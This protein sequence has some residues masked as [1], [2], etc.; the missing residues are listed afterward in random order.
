MATWGVREG[1]PSTVRR[2]AGAT[3]THKGPECGVQ[4][5][6]GSEELLRHLCIKHAAAW[7]NLV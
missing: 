2:H 5:P 6:W 1:D 7:P 4:G 3:A